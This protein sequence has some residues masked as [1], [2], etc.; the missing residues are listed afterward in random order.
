MVERNEGLKDI[1][2]NEATKIIVDLGNFY[3]ERRRPL[4]RYETSVPA[5]IKLTELELFAI[6]YHEYS[7]KGEEIKQI[8]DA[9]C[10]S[11]SS[12]VL[13]FAYTLFNQGDTQ[14]RFPEVE[15]GPCEFIFFSILAN[16]IGFISPDNILTVDDAAR[17]MSE[18]LPQMI[19]EL[20]LPG[21]PQ[22]KI[23]P[24]LVVKSALSGKLR[25]IADSELPK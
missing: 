19:K 13:N 24:E 6:K 22:D 18:E 12:R 20:E 7:T 3:S 10:K 15:R 14:S 4:G 1:R 9:S 21:S 8:F 2:L 5:L 16:R 25:L 17:R 23:T 11:N